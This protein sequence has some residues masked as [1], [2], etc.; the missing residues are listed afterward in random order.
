MF[1][2][3]VVPLDGTPFSEWGLP[4]AGSIASAS[5]A[6]IH[7]VRVHTP[8]PSDGLSDSMVRSTGA[9]PIEADRRARR[10][11]IEYLRRVER[12]LRLLDAEVASALLDEGDVV[13]RL[14]VHAR[15]VDADVVVMTSHTRGGLKPLRQ[16]SVAD[17]LVRT[18]GLP[19]LIIQPD[20]QAF[21]QSLPRRL[22]HIL[23]PLDWSHLAGAV[24][25]PVL[26]L[27][28]ALGARITLTSVVTPLLMGPTAPSVTIEALA[29]D[30]KRARDHLQAMAD[31]LRD[32]GVDVHAFVVSA[33][34]PARGIAKVAE[35]CRADLI[36]MATHGS[37][38]LRRTVAGSVT[39]DVLH[40]SA[41]P[42]MVVRPPSRA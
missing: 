15:Q 10:E 21:A 4:L 8:H 42:V 12:E 18:S 35:A 32:E 34:D 36:A 25:P 13:E 19:I 20:R 27:A 7:L 22:K 39:D 16:L 9:D 6:T 31:E 2:S 40:Q 33:T 37:G 3:I 38:G 30:E 41:L 14:R 1:D 29:L 5:H 11:E 24:F 23:V 17:R 28:R 26:D